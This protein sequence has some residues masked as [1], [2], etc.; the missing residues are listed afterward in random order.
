MSTGKSRKVEYGKKKPDSNEYFKTPKRYLYGISGYLI[1]SSAKRE[2]AKPYKLTVTEIGHMWTNSSKKEKDKYN[3]KADKLR[4]F[5]YEKEEKLEQ[6]KKKEKKSL[7]FL[8]DFENDLDNES[9][10]NKNTEKHKQVNNIQHN[11]LNNIKNKSYRKKIEKINKKRN[12]II[13]DEETSN[14][15]YEEK[16]IKNKKIF[17]A[18][19]KQKHDEDSNQIDNSSSNEERIVTT[20]LNFQ[21]KE[22]LLNRNIQSDNTQQEENKEENKKEEN[23]EENKK[24]ENKEDRYNKNDIRE[25]EDKKEESNQTIENSDDKIIMDKNQQIETESIKTEESN[26]EEN[27]LNKRYVYEFPAEYQFILKLRKD[28]KIF[29]GN[30]INKSSPLVNN[31]NVIDYEIKDVKSNKSNQ[32]TNREENEDIIVKK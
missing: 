4:N 6:R 2:E 20:D 30:K 1:F 31:F 29:E 14:N 11:N 10:Y 19:N 21:E 27:L 18:E 7:H 25:E 23:K 22:N 12:E 28:G 24:E 26:K 9:I 32:I 15:Q 17:Q 8:N 13:E 16:D 5:I 3:E